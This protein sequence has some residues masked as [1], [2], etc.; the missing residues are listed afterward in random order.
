M[1]YKAL[2]NIKVNGT[3]FK[4]DDVL[5][6]ENEV[7]A[8]ALVADG[9]LELV[10]TKSQETAPETTPPAYPKVVDGVRYELD[11]TEPESPI[12]AVED[13][14]FINLQE[15]PA[16]FGKTEE[17]ALA[18][19]REQQAAAASG[20]PAAGTPLPPAEP[21]TPPAQPPQPPT[22]PPVNTPA[23]TTPEQIR[24]ELESTAGGSTPPNNGQ[25]V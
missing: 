7:E 4:K 1:S 19:L 20:A 23:G 16:G 8:N 17:E 25:S 5:E 3:Q 15:S 11:G 22:E 14:T 6:M 21:P 13:A 24:Q 10:E 9:V 18:K 2:S 12:L